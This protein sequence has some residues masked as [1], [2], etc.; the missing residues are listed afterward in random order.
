MAHYTN[1][2]HQICWYTT[3]HYTLSHH[4]NIIYVTIILM[5]T[6]DDRLRFKNHF[7]KLG[8]SRII[9]PQKLDFYLVFWTDPDTSSDIYELLTP[10]D[11]KT[12]RD[13]NR[14]NLIILIRVLCHKVVEDSE[15]PVIN[16]RELLNCVRLLIKLLPVLYESANYHELETK[17][18]WDPAFDPLLFIKPSVILKKIDEIQP[19]PELVLGPALVNALVSLLF[20][21]DF[22]ITGPTAIWEP[23]IGSS[24]KYSPPNTVHDSNRAEILKLLLTLVS[25]TFYQQPSKII[26]SGSRFL[27]FL[28]A[29]TPRVKLLTLVCSLLNLACR[30]ARDEKSLV[31]P[32]PKLTEVRY[33]SITYSMQLL[34]IMITYPIPNNESVKF[35]TDLN[36]IATKPHNLAR[37]Y[38]GKLHKET[39]LSFVTSSLLNILKMPLSTSNEGFFK[40]SSQPSLWAIEVIVLIWELL[41]CNKI[42]RK[43]IHERYINELAILLLFYI[44]TYQYAPKYKNLVQVCCYLLLYISS[45]LSQANILFEPIPKFYET[46]PT[47]FKLNPSPVTTRDFLVTVICNML[48]NS[49]V[50]KSPVSPTLVEILYN[51][52]P[53]VSPTNLN[54]PQD[55][56]KKLNNLNPFGGLSYSTCFAITNLLTQF[57]SRTFLLEN[58]CNLDLLALLFS[59]ITTAIIKYP[60]PSRML[61][62]SILKNEKL[63]NEIWTLVSSFDTEYFN[64]DILISK[65]E[66]EEEEISPTPSN[67]TEVSPKADSPLDSEEA[68]AIEEA[69]RPK[70][71]TGMSERKREKFIKESPLNRTWGGLKSLRII[72]TIIIP[73]LKLSLRDIWSPRDGSSVESLV[74]VKHIE[75]IDFGAIVSKHR[76]QINYDYLPTSPFESLKF[77]WSYLSLGWYMAILY[78]EVYN[79]VDNVKIFTGNNS[80][81]MRNISTSIA[82]VSKFTSGWT[83]FIN[84]GVPAPDENEATIRYV[85]SSLT[86]I[87]VWSQTAVKL[88]K[89]ET[90]SEGFFGSIKKANPDTPGTPGGVNDMANNL[91][92]R[93][94]DFRLNNTSRASLSSG[95]STPVEEQESM[96]G[97]YKP[98]NSVSSLQSFNTLNRTRSNTPRNSISIDR[99]PEDKEK[100]SSIPSETTDIDRQPLKPETKV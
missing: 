100:L 93:I 15:Q 20:V 61:L 19:E 36:L 4:E 98:R 55:H 26:A 78:G 89:V 88:F 52:I 24:C 9:P 57:S 28:V 45:N 86:S 83:S 80:K 64:G 34:S 65:K 6:S 75:Q 12:I 35:L 72:L 87:N 23:G 18:F 59:A 68:K 67:E 14:I 53:A 91:V 10:Y 31:F 62:F 54:L 1:G 77:N 73:H 90:T 2:A 39:E 44:E 42:F 94:S 8:Q 37:L 43:G 69:L 56:T 3:S 38:I 11:I 17:I 32:N 7:F 92:R 70:L 29:C 60:K 76:G 33:L 25:T 21:N 95:L 97:K 66:E 79:S 81:L 22:T 47:N 58:Q 71:P 16:D 51:L 41:Q 96:F 82:S 46:L 13:Q 63:Y 49:I 40:S 27:T 30:T 99:L 85:K 50:A 48:G 74:L 84:K 5:K